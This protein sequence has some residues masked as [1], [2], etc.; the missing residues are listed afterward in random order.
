MKGDGHH[1]AP[2][3]QCGVTTYRQSMVC[4]KCDPDFKQRS[5]PGPPRRLPDPRLWPEDYLERCAAE[6]LKRHEARE[7]ALVKLGLR[8]AA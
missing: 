5:L 2:C 3:V 1:S 8:R 7:A 4:R 6:L